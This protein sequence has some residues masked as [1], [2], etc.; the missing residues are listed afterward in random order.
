[1]LLGLFWV[2]EGEAWR[3]LYTV[4]LKYAQR[5]KV[6]WSSVSGMLLYPLFSVE[7]SQFIREDCL[8]KAAC[9]MHVSTCFWLFLPLKSSYKRW[10]NKGLLFTV[11][12]LMRRDARCVWLARRERQREFDDGW[13]GDVEWRGGLRERE[14]E[15]EADDC[16][17][18][19]RARPLASASV[20]VGLDLTIMSGFTGNI[21]TRTGTVCSRW[22]YREMAWYLP[23]LVVTIIPRARE[24]STDK[25][26]FSDRFSWLIMDTSNEI[27]LLEINRSSLAGRK[28]FSFKQT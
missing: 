2:W 21:H 9:I 12:T 17:G 16:V 11:D 13:G 23:P 22:L 8:P 26:A 14:R 6:V 4:L 15:R 10:R 24:N 5:T 1:M 18:A 19:E 27:F 3:M 7:V 25:V 20:V 28:S